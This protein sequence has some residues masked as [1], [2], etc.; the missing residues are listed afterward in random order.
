MTATPDTVR[1]A[2]ASNDLGDRLRAVNDIRTLPAAEGLPLIQQAIGDANPRVRYA[3]VSQLD[4]L[5]S[6]NRAVVVDVLRDRLLN[7]PEVDVQAAAADCLGALQA[8]ETF[9][10]LSRIYQQTEEWLLRFSILAALGELG[11]SRCFD[12]LAP[13]I[14]S[15]NELERIAAIGALGELGDDRAVALLLP[16]IGED[17]WQ[18]RSRVA[19]ALGHF[20]THPDVATALETLAQDPVESVANAAR[21]RPTSA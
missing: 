14:A 11:D 18:V 13:A 2:L 16:L 5:G 21:D 10:D 12:L 3:A 8:V 17:D 20:A 6:Q 4:G 19:Q 7:D 1:Q 15:D 9:D